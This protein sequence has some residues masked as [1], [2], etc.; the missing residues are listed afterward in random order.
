MDYKP[1]CNYVRS[2]QV[3]Y[4]KEDRDVEIQLKK[5]LAIIQA[6]IIF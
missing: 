2:E 3:G 1:L 5:T 4:V 6:I